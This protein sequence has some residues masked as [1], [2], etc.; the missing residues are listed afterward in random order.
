MILIS[1]SKGTALPQ[2]LPGVD[3][4]LG[5]SNKAILENLRQAYHAGG[6][7][8]LVSVFGPTENPASA[9]ENPIA[10]A[11]KLAAFV[12]SNLLDGA[13]IMWDDDDSLK[14][15]KA[16]AWLIDF[17]RN[18][19]IDYPTTS[20]STRPRQSIIHKTILKEGT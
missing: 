12:Q 19:E 7:K 6:V 8:I 2:K 9:W 5:S 15:A 18:S 4:G 20:L 10:C 16:E 17:T 3:S 13:D 14:E 11:N 1:T